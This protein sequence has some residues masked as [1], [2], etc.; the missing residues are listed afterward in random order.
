MLLANGLDA[1]PYTV[2]FDAGKAMGVVLPPG[3]G[4][5]CRRCG[6]GDAFLYAP[7]TFLG[8]DGSGVFA[9]EWCWDQTHFALVRMFKL[10]EDGLNGT[11]GFVPPPVSPP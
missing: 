6:R 2:K 1:G 10:V 9:C 8:P 7:T 5:A 4:L 11:G 3:S